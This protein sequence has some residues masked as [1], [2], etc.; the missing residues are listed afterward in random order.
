[1]KYIIL[2]LLIE[3]NLYFPF[4]STQSCYEQGHKLMTSIAKYQ[5][6]GPEQGWYTDRGDLVYGFYCE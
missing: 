5:G 4:D 2:L 1:M 3:G 6:P